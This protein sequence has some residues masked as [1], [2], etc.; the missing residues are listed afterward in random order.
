MAKQLD[1]TQNHFLRKCLGAYR[2]VNGRVLEKEADIELITTTLEKLIAK[3]VKRSVSL[4]G[5]RIIQKA[6]NRIRNSA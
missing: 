2:A 6:Y 3:A 4:V 1:T 5:G